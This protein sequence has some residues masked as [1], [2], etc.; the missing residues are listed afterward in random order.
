M[1]E[2]TL[3]VLL[4][5]FVFVVTVF[6]SYPNRVNATEEVINEDTVSKTEAENNPDEEPV[7]A[8]RAVATDIKYFVLDGGTIVGYSGVNLPKAVVI[9]DSYEKDGATIS[10]TAIGNNAFNSK[11]LTSVTMGDNII[12]IGNNAFSNNAALTKVVLSKNLKTLGSYAFQGCTKLSS[13]LDLSNLTKMGNN[14]FDGCEY[15]TTVTLS[16]ELTEI[17]NYAF[18]NNKKLATINLPENITRIGNGAFYS[19]TALSSITFPSKLETI[20]VSAFYYNTALKVIDFSHCQS[21]TS[22]GENAFSS[23]ARYGN[24]EIDLPEGLKTIGDKAF[25]NVGLSSVTFPS[26]IESISKNAFEQN[27]LMN[28]NT[29]KMYFK[30]K[31]INGVLGAPW[32]ALDPQIYWDCNDHSAYYFNNEGEILGFKPLDHPSLEGYGDVTSGHTVAEIPSMI[33]DVTITSIADYAFANSKL[34]RVKLPETVKNI[35]NCSFA[36][37]KSLQ[38]VE[39]PGVVEVKNSAFGKTEGYLAVSCSSLNEVKFG[40]SITTIASDAFTSV[41]SECKIYLIEKEVDSV[42]G[43]PWDAPGSVYIYWKEGNPTP[44]YVTDDGSLLGFKPLDHYSL[45][46]HADVTEGHT[47]ANIPAQI[48]GIDVVKIV[49]NAFA[50]TPVEEL[51]IPDSVNEIGDRAFQNTQIVS[52]SLS[53]HIKTY[54]EY[55]FA[56]CKNLSQVDLPIEMTK[57]PNY[58]FSKCTS[59]EQIVLPLMLNE[60]GEGA[61]KETGL[62]QINFPNNIQ[63]L[64]KLCFSYTKINQVILPDSITTVGTNVF[65]ECKELSKVRLSS[66]IDRI[67]SS[68]F[69]GNTKLEDIILPASIKNIDSYAF[70]SC[71]S[72]KKISIPKGVESIAGYAFQNTGITSVIFP[73]G[74]RSIGIG[75]FDGVNISENIYL[76]SSLNSIDTDTFTGYNAST[77]FVDKYENE[78]SG[79]PWGAP[80]STNVLFK[81]QYVGVNHQIHYSQNKGNA[82]IDLTFT[83]IDNSTIRWIELPNGTVLNNLDVEEYHY[84]YPVNMNGV[85]SFKTYSSNRKD[86]YKVEVNGIEYATIDGANIIVKYND[87][88]TLTEEIIKNRSMIRATHNQTGEK[89]AVHME[90]DLATIISNLKA[91]GNTEILFSTVA[92][93]PDGSTMTYYKTISVFVGEYYTVMY[94]DYDDRV[95]SVQYVNSGEDATPPPSPVRKGYT[96]S[97]WDK[98]S[99]NVKQDLVIHAI[100]TAKSYRVTYNLNGGSWNQNNSATVKW[101]DNIIPNATPS[102]NGYRFKG[103][104]LNNSETILSED[105]FYNEVVNYDD[106]KTSITLYAVYDIEEYQINFNSNGG[107]GTMDPIKFIVD[108]R[109]VQ[110]PENKFTKIGFDFAGWNTKADGSGDKIADKGLY[111]APL[112]SVTLYAQWNVQSATYY[113]EIPE[114][115]EL[116]NEVDSSYAS[117]QQQVSLHDA[118][119]VLNDRTIEILS[120]CFITLTNNNTD[121]TYKV[122]V[123][124]SN[125]ESHDNNTVP[126]MVLSTSH[127]KEIFT[128]RTPQN[129]S[130]YKGVYKGVLTFK[131]RFGGE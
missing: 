23:I 47:I 77:I 124:K 74:L 70:M 96:F 104:K 112:E 56:E 127:E 11:Q 66:N 58:I 4:C 102:K 86:T 33:E 89:L 51:I 88:N 59:L 13:T 63:V 31:G 107:S 1:C 122:D 19:V 93:L 35:G 24:I 80:N 15:L 78:L 2:K 105:T 99:T 118:N 64:G 7:I 48:G 14:A 32:G 130:K 72:L 22:I 49:A 26:T 39:A 94:L 83:A 16:N 43:A 12:S 44:F 18:R 121:D 73:E 95:I 5:L 50:N 90:S 30:N 108:T 54:G 128:L 129:N 82:V 34:V 65:S 21:L 67:S 81:G 117:S 20:G 111:T 119:G 84:E 123:Y 92:T 113:V 126:L 17:P 71:S 3:K 62:K 103:W 55:I 45:E 69:A 60:I 98:L 53:K 46:G 79:K 101:N 8:P 37:S 97:R 27:S 125:G 29:I 116:K 57:I 87:I 120:E 106:T 100:Y 61:F 38:T 10:I 42:K 91:H 28:P 52:V 36:G 25:Y 109:R 110:L 68:M 40:S 76:P 75:A 41:N 6:S 115:I 114:K 9:P 85:Y 131:I